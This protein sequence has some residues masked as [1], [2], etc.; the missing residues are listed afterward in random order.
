MIV[1]LLVLVLTSD[2]TTEESAQPT[3]LI[4][5]AAG[6][7]GFHTARKLSN[8][9]PHYQLVGLDNFDPYYDVNLKH[10]RANLL[11]QQSDVTFYEGDVCDERL[12]K[13]MFDKYHVTMVIHL[14]A[15]AGV[16]HSINDPLAYVRSN[17]ECFVVLLEQLRHHNVS[18]SVTDS[19]KM[20]ILL[21][22]RKQFCCMHH[23]PVFMAK[24]LHCHF[25][26]S[27]VLVTLVTFMQHQSYPM[28]CLQTHIVMS[29]RCGL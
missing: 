3:I 28:R 17:I 24:I 8:T 19:T 13:H 15:Q 25:L 16:R 5:G 26:L 7:I 11:Q 9:K 10:H 27:R 2:T 18:I 21:L 12:L 29:T 14:A 23:R 1:V 20:M 6:F 4:T 22:Y